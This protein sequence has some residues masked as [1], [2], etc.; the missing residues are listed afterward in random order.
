MKNEIAQSSDFL[1]IG[2]GIAGLSYALRVAEHGTV[3]VLSKRD[4]NE[5]NTRYAQ[6]G[7]AAVISPL[8]STQAHIDDTLIAGDGICD[9]E[10]VRITTSE[11]PERIA[12]LIALGTQFDRDAENGEEGEYSLGREGGHSARRILHSGD[13]T[14][15]EIQRALST[16]ATKSENIR[17]FEDHL[18][19]DFIRGDGNEIQ[20]CYALCQKTQKIVSFAAKTTLLASGGVGKVYLY[21]SNPDV[22]SGDGIAMAWR[23]G[24]EIANMEF[25]QFHPTC[26]F[27][28]R[29]KSFLITE[30]LR[31]EGALL[32]LPNGERFMPQYD[33][34]AE[35]APRDIVARAI[36]DQMKR[37][38]LDHVLLDITHQSAEF[39][40]RRF[41]TIAA[42]LQ[43]FGLDMSVDQIPVVPAAHYCCGGVKSDAHGRTNLDGLY[44]A[45]ETACTGLHGANRLASNSLLEAVVFAARA[46][47][48]SI[49][50]LEER[51]LPRSIPE[52]DSLDASQNSEQVL[53]SYTWDEVR[54]LMWNLVGI[55]RSD[56]R[57]Y[58]AKRRIEHILQEIDN[59]Y[60]EFLVTSDFVE[61]RNIA[62]VA[63]LI[64]ESA[65]SRKESRGL[66]FTTDYPEQ[67]ESP[68]SFT[69]LRKS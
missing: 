54:R 23:A 55:V 31:G 12:E 60:W 49:A 48:D 24:A 5:G 40:N 46:A 28:P 62:T 3:T 6:G 25:I 64:I 30:A 44:T 39:L 27:H 20:G 65:L 10:I 35:L 16:A 36:D 68:A 4:T 69:V 34:R 19:V 33:E 51:S 9:S 47:E 63:S 7:I 53:V 32:K 38:G 26:L 41:P 59:H 15:A 21:T 14:G 8:D 2:S 29:A 42:R 13:A 57:L 61:V 17:C 18:A 66:H 50:T 45:G 43:D 1:V 37:L 22:A 67:A 56:K 58:L 52:W 11:G